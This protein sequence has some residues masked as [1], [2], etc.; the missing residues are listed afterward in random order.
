MLI[1]RQNVSDDL[2]GFG[3]KDTFRP[4]KRIT[5]CDPFI[6]L[7]HLGFFRVNKIA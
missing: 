2:A 7:N 1:K 4:N 3:K 6:I 5:D